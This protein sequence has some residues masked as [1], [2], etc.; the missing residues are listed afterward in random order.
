M[1][2]FLKKDALKGQPFRIKRKN[3]AFDYVRC[4]RSREGD[5]G[6]KTL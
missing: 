5:T 4:P 1:R 2:D 3:Y 6:K